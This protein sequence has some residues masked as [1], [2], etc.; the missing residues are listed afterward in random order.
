MLNKIV[1]LSLLFFSSCL[2]NPKHSIKHINSQSSISI[3]N[4]E[5]MPNIENSFIY[6]IESTEIEYCSVIGQCQTETIRSY[7]SGFVINHDHKNKKTYILTAGHCCYNDTERLIKNNVIPPLHALV[8]QYPNYSVYNA[9]NDNYKAEIINIDKNKD[10]CLLQT[11]MMTILPLKLSDISPVP[12][13]KV[14]NVSAPQ[15]LWS[16]NNMIKFTGFYN[17]TD[18]EHGDTFIIMSYPG[19]SGS[20]IVNK[21]GEVVSMVLRVMP[22]SNTI[23]FGANIQELSDFVESNIDVKYIHHK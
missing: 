14:Y 7:S 4:K 13:E 9:N 20:P 19:S 23:T 15:G 1:I 21:N 6:I 12:L 2:T 10:F 22:P 16:P 8:N 11:D 17:G 3:S 18:E 5:E